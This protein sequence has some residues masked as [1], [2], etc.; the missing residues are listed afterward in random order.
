MFQVGVEEAYRFENISSHE[1]GATNRD[2]RRFL[3]QQQIVSDPTIFPL[4]PYIDGVTSLRVE[5]ANGT[6]NQADFRVALED[7]NLPFDFG[8]I[9]QVIGIK[10]CDQFAG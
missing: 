9:K 10:K 5:L 7:F 1:A 3:E 6:M 8:W 2:Y 4:G